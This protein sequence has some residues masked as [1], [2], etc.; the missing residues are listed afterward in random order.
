M[1]QNI[2]QAID[3]LKGANVKVQ[4]ESHVFSF[5]DR[6]TC[7]YYFEQ[8]FRSVDKTSSFEWLPEYKA[9]IDWMQNTKGK[10]LFLRGD[11]GRGKSTIICSVLPVLFNMFFKKLLTP[12]HAD[13][14]AKEY[15]DL[16]WK[17]FSNVI[18]E[19]GVEEIVTNYGEPFEPFNKV[20]NAAEAKNKLLFITS[21]LTPR[22]ILDR[23]GERT[24]DRIARLC[25]T[26][27]FKGDSLRK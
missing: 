27:E 19:L 3:E 24:V 14:L 21:N 26:I 8:V 10:G 2:K 20:I 7:V 18:D 5:G 11:C 1:N 6:N 17:P 4:R 23:Y 13:N 25:K 16:A 12:V 15:G 9:I 22:Q